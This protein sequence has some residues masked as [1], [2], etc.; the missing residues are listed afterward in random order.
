MFISCTK[1]RTL[2]IIEE[3]EVELGRPVLSSIAAS[4]WQLVGHMQLPK[5]PATPR[6][7]FR[8]RGRRKRPGKGQGLTRQTVKTN[9]VDIMT[10]YFARRL[11][12]ASALAATMAFAAAPA[13]AQDTS[14]ELVSGTV[15]GS[16]FSHMV[17]LGETVFKPAG[18][19]YNNNP[20]GGTSNVMALATG[21]ADAG[22][23]MPLVLS[24]AAA[25]LE[26]F[27]ERI[28]NVSVLAALYPDPW[29]LVVPADSEIESY[30][31]P[32]G[33]HASGPPPG[34]LSAGSPGHLLETFDRRPK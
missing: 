21:Q 33:E 19:E 7:D 31:G 3:L 10:L 20:G 34:R 6:A 4:L 22:F 16:W 8:N 27:S 13:W 24:M 29:E 15:T 1:L 11:F 30:T 2:E 17:A 18:F 26:P 9:E 25:G 14:L 23:T 32:E 12:S 28:D 5:I